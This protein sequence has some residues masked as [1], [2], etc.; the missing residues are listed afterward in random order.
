MLK[1]T[2]QNFIYLRGTKFPL[3]FPFDFSCRNVLFF[4]L[5]NTPIIFEL[6]PYLKIYD[7][8]NPVKKRQKECEKGLFCQSPI[9]ASM[10]DIS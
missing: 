5:P 3:R 8:Q 1:Y 2:G 9:L 7:R 10:L 6:Q 4:A